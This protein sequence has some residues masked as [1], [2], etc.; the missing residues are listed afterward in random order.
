MVPD[1]GRSRP[2]PAAGRAASPGPRAGLASLAKSVATM[3]VRFPKMLQT[4][5]AEY[6]TDTK[7][8]THIF[9]FHYGTALILFLSLL[10]C[11]YTGHWSSS[12]RNKEAGVNKME[13]KKKSGTSLG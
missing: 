13:G 10:L 3:T 12:V 8:V 11:M 1:P 6:S 5:H 9:I 4:A 2:N 7:I